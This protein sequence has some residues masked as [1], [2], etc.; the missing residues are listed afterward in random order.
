MQQPWSDI[1]TARLQTSS[2]VR[3]PV[4]QAAGRFCNPLH[5]VSLLVRA[6]PDVMMNDPKLLFILTFHL[7]S[8]PRHSQLFSSLYDGHPREAGWILLKLYSLSRLPL[9]RELGPRTFPLLPDAFH[10][11]P[12]GRNRPQPRLPALY[13]LGSRLFFF[14]PFAEL[15]NL[16]GGLVFVFSFVYD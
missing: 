1:F 11:R 4:L 13:P 8:P 5:L 16:C 3:P 9:C 12:I 2:A 15:L 14:P 6:L 7:T 10:F